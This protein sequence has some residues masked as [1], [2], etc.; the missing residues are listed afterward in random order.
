[1]LVLVAKRIIIIFFIISIL[2]MMSVLVCRMTI[3]TILTLVMFLRLYLLR[4]SGAS[5]SAGRLNKIGYSRGDSRSQPC[6]SWDA[7]YVFIGTLGAEAFAV[8]SSTGLRIRS[9]LRG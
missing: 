1:M 8:E 9:G 3:I 2:L 7:S 5:T 4:E 6:R